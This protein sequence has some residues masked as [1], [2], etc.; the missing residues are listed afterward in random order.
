MTLLHE[1]TP[2][3]GEAGGIRGVEIADNTPTVFA[4]SGKQRR[5][6][7]GSG[8]LCMAPGGSAT[9]VGIE[10]TTSG[11]PLTVLARGTQVAGK[12]TLGKPSADQPWQA[13]MVAKFREVS[14]RTP[15]IV[16]IFDTADPESIS[17]KEAT[18]V[19]TVK[20]DPGRELGMRF[21][22]S[23]QEGFE[24][25]HTYLVRVAQTTIQADGVFDRILAE[26]TFHLE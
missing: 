17:R 25:S 23:P 14:D 13:E 8:V 22:L 12:G 18:S 20:M 2:L 3:A 24:P 26:G 6:C 21:L 9:M 15:I 19:W 16:A 4:V 11:P 5:E 7:S 10:L 1:A